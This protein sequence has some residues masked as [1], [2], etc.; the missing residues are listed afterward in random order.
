MSTF[1]EQINQ[2]NRDLAEIQ[3]VARMTPKKMFWQWMNV[4]GWLVFGIL[5]AVILNTIFGY[6]IF[7]DSKWFTYP[8]N[9][10]VQK[11]LNEYI[12]IPPTLAVIIIIFL[13]LF[14]FWFR[15]FWNQIG[16]NFLQI[17]K[18]EKLIFAGYGF[19]MGLEM[20]GF[21]VNL[22]SS[23]NIT[24]STVAL[25]FHYLVFVVLVGR[26]GK[27]MLSYIF[28]PFKYIYEEK[29]KDEIVNLLYPKPDQN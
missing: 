10:D 22:G 4:G 21:K 5:V 18:T 27:V 17:T 23:E 20:L 13:V 3:K 11:F 8:L 16:A 28:F 29:T 1:T 6:F 25:V 12:F 26:W 9:K 14:F 15:S 2:E 19:W 7:N 24:W